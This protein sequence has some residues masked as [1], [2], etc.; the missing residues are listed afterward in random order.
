M[1]VTVVCTTPRPKGNQ[2]MSGLGVSAM[3]QGTITVAALD[4]IRSSV[5]SSSGLV[6]HP[7]LQSAALCSSFALLLLHLQSRGMMTACDCPCVPLIACGA[8]CAPLIACDLSCAPLIAYWDLPCA[9]LIGVQPSDCH[10]RRNASQLFVRASSHR[11]LCARS[12]L[13]HMS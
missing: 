10:L 13:C 1:I 3:N 6:C 12:A 5:A 9:P 7:E 11:M 8:P 4:N 2:G